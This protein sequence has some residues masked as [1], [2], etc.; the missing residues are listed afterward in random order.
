MKIIA[1]NLEVGSAVLP[2]RTP[3]IGEHAK[4]VDGN[5]VWYGQYYPAPVVTDEHIARHWRNAELENTD[6]FVSVTD[7]PQHADIIVYR[8]ELRDWPDTENFPDT[9][10]NNPL[11]E[12]V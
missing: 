6:K 8:Q 11:E 7:H 9:Q 1:W 12:M 5:R 3:E 2:E 4:F 10:P